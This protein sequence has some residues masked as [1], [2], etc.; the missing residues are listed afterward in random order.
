MCMR[1]HYLYLKYALP[2]GPICT[3]NYEIFIHNTVYWVIFVLNNIR[4]IIIR[5]EKFSRTRAK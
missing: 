5:V 4:V 3:S 2:A 1:V